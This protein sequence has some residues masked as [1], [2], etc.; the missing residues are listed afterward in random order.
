M[1][2]GTLVC[3]ICFG[4][5]RTVYD[6]GRAKRAEAPYRFSHFACWYTSGAR[7]KVSG[8]FCLVI[9]NYLTNSALWK[10]DLIGL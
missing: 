2:V 8:Y 3:F 5:A 7:R 10:D 4:S 6:V 1:A 9:F